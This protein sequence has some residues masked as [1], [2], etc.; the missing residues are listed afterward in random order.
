M[1]T[2]VCECCQKEV[3][4]LPLRNAAVTAGVCRSTIYYWMERGWI[5]WRELPSGRRLICLDS[6]S[7]PGTGNVA[8]SISRT[9]IG[10]I[11]AKLP[12]QNSSSK[13]VQR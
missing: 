12:V 9:S 8:I 1:A 7:R 5:H 11:T 10:P 6:L 2:F 13:S 3:R 4:F